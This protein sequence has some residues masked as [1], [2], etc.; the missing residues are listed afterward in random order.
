MVKIDLF[1]NT[2]ILYCIFYKLRNC[3]NPALSKSVGAIF[4]TSTYFMSLILVILAVF[5]TFSLC[6]L[7]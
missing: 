1:V 3:S 4:P 6:L 5:P 7:W 2:E